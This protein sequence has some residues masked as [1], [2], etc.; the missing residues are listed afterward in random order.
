M[1]LLGKSFKVK[2]EHL[3]LDQ[4]TEKNPLPHS[5]NIKLE[6]FQDIKPIILY[7]KRYDTLIDDIVYGGVGQ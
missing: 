2:Y 1:L 5:I 7:L 3:Q 6:K 4:F